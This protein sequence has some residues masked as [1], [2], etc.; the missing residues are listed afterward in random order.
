MFL[1]IVVERGLN[2]GAGCWGEVGEDN[3]WV[4]LSV[5]RKDVLVYVCAYV[6]GNIYCSVFFFVFSGEYKKKM[7]PLFYIIRNS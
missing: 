7:N 1:Q 2:R 6:S 4:E 5:K 3:V